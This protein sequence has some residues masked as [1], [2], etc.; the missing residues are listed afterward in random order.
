MK[1]CDEKLRSRLADISQL[2][3]GGASDRREAERRLRRL[4]AEALESMIE[5]MNEREEAALVGPWPQRRRGA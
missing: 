3:D 1:M 4:E 2:A 5:A